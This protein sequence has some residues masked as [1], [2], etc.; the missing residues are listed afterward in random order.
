[1]SLLCTHAPHSSCWTMS[2]GG[3]HTQDA[4]G[5]PPPPSGLRLGT[6]N[7]LMAVTGPSGVGGSCGVRMGWGSVLPRSPLGAARD[8]R[9]G[10]T[11]ANLPTT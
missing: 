3:V 10:L 4:V 11:E 9:L 2:R 7:S 8:A 5:A 6:A 1:M